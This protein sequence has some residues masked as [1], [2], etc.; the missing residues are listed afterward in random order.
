MLKRIR[1]IIV[2]L[3]QL[4]QNLLG[5]S[6]LGYLKLVGN[7]D[8]KYKKAFLQKVNSGSVTLGE[9]IFINSHS[10]SYEEV[11]KHEYGHVFQSRIL[12]PFWIIVIGIPSII[13][14]ALHK[15]KK[16][17]YHFYTEKWANWLADKFY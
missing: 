10:R 14:A 16:D 15:S 4:P 6:Y 17:Y 9:L 13:H 8:G 11:Y 12:G 3:W 5:I 2:S 7:Y 1:N